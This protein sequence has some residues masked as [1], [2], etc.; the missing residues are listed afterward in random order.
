M[1]WR[2]II[3]YDENFSHAYT[4]HSYGDAHGLYEKYEDMILTEDP[5]APT[6]VTLMQQKWSVLKELKRLEDEE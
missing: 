6:K 4:I 5:L 1:M 3:E 2:I